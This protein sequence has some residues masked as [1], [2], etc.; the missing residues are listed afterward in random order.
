MQRKNKG[1]R[2]LII[3]VFVAAICLSECCAQVFELSFERNDSTLISEIQ[4]A[5]KNV[6]KRNKKVILQSLSLT[7][8]FTYEAEWKE[9][10]LVIQP[11]EIL[12]ELT[13]YQ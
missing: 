7:P 8:A 6:S 1:R 11:Q 13:K 12:E 10:V 9:S 3:A 4:L 5:G 2:Y